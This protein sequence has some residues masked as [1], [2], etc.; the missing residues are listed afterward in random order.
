[1]CSMEHKVSHE[2]AM[3]GELVELNSVGAVKMTVLLRGSSFRHT[4]FG[5]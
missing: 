5:K 3:P 4:R 1:M 2:S